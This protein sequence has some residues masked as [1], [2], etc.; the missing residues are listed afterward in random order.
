MFLRKLFNQEAAS[1]YASLVFPDL[2][3]TQKVENQKQAIISPAKV[4]GVFQAPLPSS[5][6]YQICCK[7]IFRDYVFYK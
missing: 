5:K 2:T 1:N 4:S 7:F 6:F 3:E